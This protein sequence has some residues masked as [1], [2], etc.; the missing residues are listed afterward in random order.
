M[1]SIAVM[2]GTAIAF[3]AANLG[4]HYLQKAIDGPGNTDEERKRHDRALEKYQ[5]D[6]GEYEKQRTRLRDWEE[7]REIA[8]QKARQDLHQGDEALTLYA[9]THPPPHIGPEP[10]WNDYYK[11]SK[12]QKTMEL[13][14][15][16]GGALATAYVV[17]KFF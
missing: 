13:A 7:N 4:A 14:V 6:M 2:I 16:G 1:A 17:S 3:S 11:P 8:L 15:V 9:R 12:R 10:E 5:H